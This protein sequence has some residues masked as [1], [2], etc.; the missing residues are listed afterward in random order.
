MLLF[1]AKRVVRR[2]TDGKPFEAGLV[3]ALALKQ[4]LSMEQVL[5]EQIGLDG[6]DLNNARK[7]VR[8]TCVCVLG[9]VLC[10]SFVLIIKS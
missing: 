7:W 4:G 10:V 6:E 5:A 1:D 8:G 2:G 3:E 9:V